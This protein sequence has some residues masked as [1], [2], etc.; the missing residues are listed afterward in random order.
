MGHS[1]NL[2]ILKE[3]YISK[4]K[5]QRCG[6]SADGGNL[7]KST[8]LPNRAFASGI[9]CFTFRELNGIESF[10]NKGPGVLEWCPI[11]NDGKTYQ[12][13]LNCAR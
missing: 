8:G 10:P 4:N 6:E 1:A 13:Y 2:K 7:S 5:M 9:L 3:A 12:S 11:S